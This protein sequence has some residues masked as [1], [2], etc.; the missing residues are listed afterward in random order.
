MNSVYDFRSFLFERTD[1]DIITC[2]TDCDI[3]KKN[4]YDN[5]I[6]IYKDMTLGLMDYYG[7]DPKELACAKEIEIKKQRKRTTK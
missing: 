6:E 4:D 3:I 1:Y 5:A 7:F 2:I